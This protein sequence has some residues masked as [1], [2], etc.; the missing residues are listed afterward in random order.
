MPKNNKRK[1]KT[2]EQ[3]VVSE[4]SQNVFADLGFP[5]AEEHETKAK[6][7]IQITKI[8]KQ[9]HL[10]QTE[11]ATRLEIDQPRV[12]DMLNGKLRGFS[13]YRL[14]HFVRLLGLEINIVTKDPAR[15]SKIEAIEVS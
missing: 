12:S 5:D 7:V 10:T 2:E 9:K 3:I 1:V 6:L 15:P 13:V 14:M 11:A 8:I 4:A